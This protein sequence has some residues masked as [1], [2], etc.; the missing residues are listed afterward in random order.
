MYLHTH[1]CIHICICVI[2]VQ[3][4]VGDFSGFT[5]DKLLLETEKALSFDTLYTP[6][7]RL[8]ELQENVRTFK[9]LGVFCPVCIV[10]LF[11]FSSSGL[12]FWRTPSLFF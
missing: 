7:T 8:I 4:K 9:F 6:H 3:D 1:A 2:Y 11:S 5:P 10:F 12:S